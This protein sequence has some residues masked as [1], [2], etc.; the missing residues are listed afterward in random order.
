MHKNIKAVKR[1][2]SYATGCKTL[3]AYKSCIKMD[4]PFDNPF[5]FFHLK[6][7]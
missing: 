6:R 4:V 2:N 1:A 3:D 7:K 5:Y